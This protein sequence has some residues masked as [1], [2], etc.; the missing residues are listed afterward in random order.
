MVANY[1]FH[2]A[3]SAFNAYLRGVVS[4]DNAP[5][6]CTAGIA[7]ICVSM[8]IYFFNSASNISSEGLVVINFS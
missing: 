8:A 2:D 1:A 4:N 5:I 3:A 7:L 6:L